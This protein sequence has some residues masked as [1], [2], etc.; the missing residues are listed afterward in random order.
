MQ[1]STDQ[2]VGKKIKKNITPTTK[3]QVQWEK[4]SAA[5]VILCWHK[6]L[7]DFCLATES[8]LSNIL[9]NVQY[10]YI[11]LWK[12]HLVWGGGTAENLC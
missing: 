9:Q 12:K 4:T 11:N 6:A 7:A 1:W 10:D 2:S 8:Q 5:E 3:E